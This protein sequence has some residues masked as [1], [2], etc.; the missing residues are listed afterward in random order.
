M[1]KSDSLFAEVIAIGDELT[2]GQRLDTNSQWLSQQ[3]GD[4]GIRTLFHTTVADDLKSNVLAFRAAAER[5]DLVIATGGLGPTA[6]DL[7]R[8]AIAEA[9]QLP[10][11]LHQDS[12]ERI[13]AM[14]QSRGR[15]M[16]ERNRVQ[17]LFPAGSV[18]VLNPHGTAPGIDISASE[19]GCRIFALPGVPAEMK[20]MFAE[21]IR[22]LLLRQ[23]QGRLRPV[24]HYRLKCFGA[25]E[26]AVE[27]MLPD[28]VRRGR[29]PTVGITVSKATITLRVSGQAENE[30][31][32]ES[33]IGPTVQTIREKL[34]KLV[35]GEED[36]ELQ[37]VITRLLAE[38]EKTLAVSEWGT[39]G[40]V[41]HWMQDVASDGNSAFAGGYV[42]ANQE[43]LAS[44]L[45]IRA[46]TLS[47]QE[48][49]R[50]MA[51]AAKQKSGADL[52]LAVGP[53]PKNTGSVES[54]VFFGL[55][56]PDD[57]SVL[58]RRFAGHPSILAPRAAKQALDTLRLWLI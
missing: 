4:L 28:V 43:S 50:E 11:E 58:G 55:A 52:G 40:L 18:P 9:F 13:L 57:A 12:L 44:T 29:N 34:G 21:T 14:F 27:A 5:A 32:F 30:A 48:L 2:S 39:A 19:G 15:E 31:E 51:V 35:F 3:L 6:D 25:G 49:A 36:E 17:A 47:T 46:S 1:T 42:V 8:E 41:T 24:R 10:L 7:T 16:P 56:T 53:F 23:Y 22:P 33:L 20:E 26:S 38:Q 37:H 45:G 54:K